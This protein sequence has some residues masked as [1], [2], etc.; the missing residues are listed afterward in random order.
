MAR[1]GRYCCVP[2]IW[3][4]RAVRVTITCLVTP[5]RGVRNEVCLRSSIG[6]RLGAALLRGAVVEGHQRIGHLGHGSLRSGISPLPH[7]PCALLATHRYVRVQS[8]PIGWVRAAVLRQDGRSQLVPN[9][10]PRVAAM[11]AGRWQQQESSQ[12][13]LCLQGGMPSSH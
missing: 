4:F 3:L 2:R 9:V 10:M 8:C 13:S 12:P 6:A 5:Q 7:P 1:A 11:L